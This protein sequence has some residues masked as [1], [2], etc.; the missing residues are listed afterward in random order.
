MTEAPTEA[1][2]EAATEAP[3]AEGFKVGLVTDVGKV[4]D[5]TF[6]QYAYEGMLQAAE[7]FGVPNAFIETQ[8]PTDYEKNVEQFVDEGYNMIVTVGF[9]MGETT[10]KE[11]E[12]NPDLNFAIV[13][14]SYDPAIPNVQGLVFREDQAGFLGGVLAGMMSESKTVGI[15]AGMEIPPVKKFR[16]GYENGVKYICP[17]CNTIGVYIDSFTDPA[18]GKAAAESQIAEGADVI[19]G[20]GGPTGSG[21][22]LGAAQ[23][24]VWVIGV[25]QDEYF[26]TFKGGAEAGADKL[27][28]SAMKRVD[29]AVY[30]AVKDAFEDTFEGGTRVFDAASDGVGLAPYHDAEGAIP[31]EA[32]DAVN[33]AFALLA[34]GTL[35]TGVD[36]VSGDLL[37]EAMMGE[38]AAPAGDVSLVMSFV[39]SGD[40]QEILASGDQLAA[41]IA[42]RTGYDVESNV[43]TS[44][45]AV[46]E[47]MCAGNADIGW[48]NTFGYVLANERCGV[49]V[50]LATSR[51]GT[52][53]Y[54]GQ[55]IAQ[56]EGGIESVED[57]AGKTFCRPDPLSTSGWII[58]SI[59]LAAA[60]LDVENDIE[61]IDVGSHNNVV[62][63]VYNG[64]CDAGATF[65]DARSSVEDD[66]PDVMDKV[67]VVTESTDIPNDT[68]S[69][70]E[71]VDPAVREN[72]VNALL[73][74]AGTEEGQAALEQ[75]YEI[76]GLEPVDDSFYDNFRAD[77]DA[78]GFSVEDM[79][80]E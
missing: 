21:G 37:G 22:I 43:A 58:P 2:T 9:M 63:A 51:F 39:P 52:T 55:I 79:V 68:V 75:L 4:N 23:Q 8:Q 59:T 27:L 15:V 14:F 25:D 31:Q 56:A 76:E 24:G 61:V 3:A 53:T 45:A 62:T 67:V 20:A 78:S 74:V 60:G 36:P 5:G 46:I 65:V 50:A 49:D 48:L 16:N 12:A 54:K 71:S 32:K 57:L 19:F 41:M 70:A 40:T 34:E 7:E 18:R 47:A 72:V 6:N 13:D 66:I 38:P 44:Y 69:F 29:V 33:E 17:D 80:Q 35:D 42:E 26:T 77:L 64:D 1:A 11:A 30:S 10:Q 73:D 28:S